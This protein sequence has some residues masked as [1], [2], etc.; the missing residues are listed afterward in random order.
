[1]GTTKT[2]SYEI[3]SK[4]DLDAAIC[5]RCGAVDW[6]RAGKP[7]SAEVALASLFGDYDLVGTLDAVSAPGDRVLLY[8]PARGRRSALDILPAKCWLEVAPDLHASHDGAVLLLS[9]CDSSL[10]R[11]SKRL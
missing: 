8:R 9:P 2:C 4:G 10:T 11:Q 5:T 7:I 1:M 6:Y 3:R